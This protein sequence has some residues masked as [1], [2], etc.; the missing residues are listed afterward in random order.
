VVV[1]QGLSHLWVK[2]PS[3]VSHVRLFSAEIRFSYGLQ[4]WFR[5]FYAFLYG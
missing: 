2:M 1:D 5:G 3:G 4:T